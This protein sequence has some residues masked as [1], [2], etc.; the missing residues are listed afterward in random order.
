MQLSG[1]QPLS[2]SFP[3]P[4]QVDTE[5]SEALVDLAGATV[6]LTAS[7][8]TD[9]NAVSL[10]GTLLCQVPNLQASPDLLDNVLGLINDL[11]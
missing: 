7:A 9:P 8:G 10:A 3:S 4:V 2:L 5:Q 11:L 6:S 1:C